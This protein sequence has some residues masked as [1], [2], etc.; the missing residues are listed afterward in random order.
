[1]DLLTYRV[2][3][4]EKRAE[5]ADARMERIEDKLNAIQATLAGLA[6]KDSIRNW[7]LAIVAIV[8]TTGVSVSAIMLQASSN[9]LTA[10]QSGLSAVQAV[11]AA[12][13]TSPAS[14]PPASTTR[15]PAR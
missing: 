7:G 11:V 14:P 9:Q 12:A 1:M 5:V 2:G 10:F 15:S 8:V 4:F 3:Q 6:T 13:Q